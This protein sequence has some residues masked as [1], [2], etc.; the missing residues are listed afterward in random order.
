MIDLESVYFR[1][2]GQPLRHFTVREFA[3][4][5]HGGQAAYQTQHTCVYSPSN[6]TDVA[7]ESKRLLLLP[8]SC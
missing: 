2:R 6:G 5:D 7:G 3:I 1:V 4:Y 8:F